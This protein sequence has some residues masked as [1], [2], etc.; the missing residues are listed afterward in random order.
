MNPDFQEGW[1]FLRNTKT[2]H[3][4][5]QK[6]HPVCNRQ[7]VGTLTDEQPST[8]KRDRMTKFMGGCATCLRALKET[9]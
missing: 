6:D 3:Y 8:I 1:Y 7:R 5:E 4:F 9:V 2:A